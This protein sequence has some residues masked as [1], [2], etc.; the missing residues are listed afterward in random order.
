M[1]YVAYHFHWTRDEIL[2]LPHRER[3]RWVKEISKIN[4]KINT[5]TSSAPAGG[6]FG[7]GG[8]GGGGGFRGGLSLVNPDPDDE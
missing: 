6:G 3:H 4:K 5:S 1:A 2:D 8:F 7:G